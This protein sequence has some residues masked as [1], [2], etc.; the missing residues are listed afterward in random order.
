MGAKMKELPKELTSELLSL[1]TGR[2]IKEFRLDIDEDDFDSCIII[3]CNQ[4]LGEDCYDINL[5][6]LTRLMKEWCFSN[7]FSLYVKIRAD[8]IDMYEK[9]H[10]YVVQI[11]IGSD[12]NATQFSGLSELEAIAKATHYVAKQKGLLCT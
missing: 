9:D 5:D 7:G 2:T 11:G 8:I 6:T 4:D 12:R 1:I 3:S 10:F